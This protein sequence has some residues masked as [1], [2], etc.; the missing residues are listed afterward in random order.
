MK[1]QIELRTDPILIQKDGLNIIIDAG[2]G[3]GKLTDK[4]NETMA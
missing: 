2:I 4:Q 1:N 3:Y